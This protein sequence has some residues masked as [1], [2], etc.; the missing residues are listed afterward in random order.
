MANILKVFVE[1]E[2][3]RGRKA[4]IKTLKFYLDSLDE[5]NFPN[6]L[7]GL[8]EEIQ[9]SKRETDEMTKIEMDR[10]KIYQ[11]LLTSPEQHIAFMKETSE[12]LFKAEQQLLDADS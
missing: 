1:K 7:A 10:I 2:E 5:F 4:L 3:A 6:I 12:K 8:K 9:A 11:E